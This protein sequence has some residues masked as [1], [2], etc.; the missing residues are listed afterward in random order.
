MLPIY[1]DIVDEA[2]KIINKNIWYMFELLESNCAALSYEEVLSDIFPQYIIETNFEKCVTTVKALHNMVQDN[3]D[4]DELASFYELTLYHTISQWVDVA[5]DIPLDELP[6]NLCINKQ[7]MDMYDYLNNVNSYLDCM[8]QDLD[9]LHLEKM[10]SL[11]KTN[12]K[13]LEDFLHIDIEQYIELMPMDIQE[14][15]N[16]QM[17]RKKRDMDKRNMT[18]NI[19]GGQVNIAKD[20]ATINAIQ[21]NWMD[22]NEFETIIQVIKDNLSGLKK[23]DANELLDVLEQVKEEI[24]KE[25]PK[26]S[27]LQNCLKLIAPMITIA[28][29]IPVLA[30]NLQ[31][32][33]DIIIQYIINLQ[34]QIG[35]LYEKRQ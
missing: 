34:K 33:H 15:Y 28:N 20:N 29:G 21:N 25:K 17:E 6:R 14:E 30:T 19:S 13:I 1:L 4:R 16:I 26:K 27:R 10:Y 3:Y 24:D 18:V 8:F 5:N 2:K 32:L 11:Y 12:P 9:F 7:G 22:G 31:K 23:E 35:V